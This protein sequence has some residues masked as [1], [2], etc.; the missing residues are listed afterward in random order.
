M[1]QVRKVLDAVTWWLDT[2]RDFM[3]IGSEH[4]DM[5]E[6]AARQET[7]TERRCDGRGAQR[8][9]HVRV[10]RE[11]QEVLLLRSMFLREHTVQLA[12]HQFHAQRARLATHHGD[13]ADVLGDDGRVEQV[14][15]GSVVVHVS[16]KNLQRETESVD[17]GR[18]LDD[19]G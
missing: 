16:D 13:H 11:E 5:S 1:P 7:S 18:E 14:G 15:L 10:V 17:C 12:A 19:G 6:D 4:P 8:K 2:R 3:P 9:R